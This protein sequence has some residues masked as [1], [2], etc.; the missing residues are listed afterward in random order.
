MP[1]EVSAFCQILKPLD[2]RVVARIVDEHRGNHGVGTGDRAWT[3]ERHLRALLFGQLVGLTSLREIVE[4][5]SARPG[6]LYHASARIARRSTLS[7][8]SKARPAAVFRD[9]SQFMMGLL[10][11]EL[12]Q[13]GQALIRLIDGSPI[14]IRDGRFAWAE[15]D[16]RVRGLK[17]HLV[18]DPRAVHPVHFALETPKLSELKVARGLAIEPGATY[19][20]DKGYAD[21][22]WWQHLVDGGALFVTRLKNNVRRRDIQ[23][24]ACCGDPILK[25][26]TVKIGHK[27]PRGG[28]NN[29]LYE[30]ALREVVVD[31]PGKEPLY[32]VTNDFQRSAMEIAD[33]YKERWQ[34]ELFFKWIKQNLK[35]KAFHG[36]SENAV[37]IQIYVAIIAFCLLRL[38]QSSFATSHKAGAKAILTRL[39]VAL[40]SPF[41]LTN[42]APPPPK[43][44]QIRKPNPQ[45][46]FTL[47]AL[48]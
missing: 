17:L 14:P 45:L 36:R 12:R 41:D 23:P 21:Y 22:G 13:E 29:P 32:L 42:K 39:K 8:A 20:F 7:D 2:R 5:L 9:I 48:S 15:A 16:N 1:F 19:V 47:S 4:G 40:F 18:Y 44:P 46:A 26:Q 35:I 3:C 37:R 11:R 25:D 34:I 6:G 31:R 30:T 28:A 38:F 43:P 33:L 27:K 10:T 24:R